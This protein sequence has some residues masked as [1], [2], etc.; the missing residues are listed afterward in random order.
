VFKDHFAKPGRFQAS[1]LSGSL[2]A[3]GKKWTTL[4]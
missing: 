4:R 3:L 2:F 1:P